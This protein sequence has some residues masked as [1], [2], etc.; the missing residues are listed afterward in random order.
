MYRRGGILTARIH[1][2]A[3][4]TDDHNP[5]SSGKYLSQRSKTFSVVGEMATARDKLAYVKVTW[6]SCVP[7]GPA[8]C[9]CWLV[10]GFASSRLTLSESCSMRMSSSAMLDINSEVDNFRGGIWCCNCFRGTLVLAT[11]AFLRWPR[12]FSNMSCRWD[13]P[14]GLALPALVCEIWDVLPTFVDYLVS[15]WEVAIISI[16]DFLR[17]RVWEPMLC[18]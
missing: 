8:T 5:L 10:A 7:H 11:T 9:G 6:D 12:I 18:V 3:S 2:D 13:L 1:R 15:K 14:G 17:K 16:I 4:A